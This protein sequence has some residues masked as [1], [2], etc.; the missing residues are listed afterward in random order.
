MCFPYWLEP[1][2]SLLLTAYV[3]IAPVGTP[4]LSFELMTCQLDFRSIHRIL[5]RQGPD[6]N[7]LCMQYW[8]LG[9]IQENAE[10]D[11]IF[12]IRGRS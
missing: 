3:S 1:E 2:P 8:N 5:L 6:Q 10:K 4:F 7:P 12:S 9:V 11:S